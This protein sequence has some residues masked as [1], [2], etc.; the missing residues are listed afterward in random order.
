M[1]PQT[2]KEADLDLSVG[3]FNWDNLDPEDHIINWDRFRPCGMVHLAMI[4]I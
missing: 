1:N 4:L 2:V 3:D